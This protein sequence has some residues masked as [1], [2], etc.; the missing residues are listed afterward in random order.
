MNEL[1]IAGWTKLSTVDWPGN[2]VTTIFLQGCP[3]RCSY[4]HNYQI[5][6]PQI[7]GDVQF[8]TILE[9]LRSRV[10]LLDGVVFSGGEA[11]MQSG[12]NGA[13]LDSIKEVLAIDGA[14]FIKDTAAYKIG[15]HTA[16]AY[17]NNLKRLLPYLD[18]I[19]FDVKAPAGLYDAITKTSAS[20]V[21][22]R[23]SLNLVLAERERRKN[24]NH[25][26]SV[27]FRTTVDPFVLDDSAISRLRE[28][29]SAKGIDDLV[30]QEVRSEGVRQ[31]YA[32]AL[33]KIQ[34]AQA[35]AR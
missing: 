24:T 34:D 10:G 11:L 12:G 14:S 8:D 17:P 6:D 20:E 16:G 7:R 27:Q 33:A 9:F 26:L 5:L 35:R 18:W 32:D 15:L 22:A 25:P 21:V 29:L 3:W 31:E 23:K 30:H 4:C 28:E 13:L 1:N 2:I 19:G